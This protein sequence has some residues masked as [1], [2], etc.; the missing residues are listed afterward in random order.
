[1][2]LALRGSLFLP[3][4]PCAVP[5]ITSTRS[6]YLNFCPLYSAKKLEPNTPSPLGTIEFGEEGKGSGR[7]LSNS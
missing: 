3:T 2:N 4:T 5:I 1:L 7:R 6:S